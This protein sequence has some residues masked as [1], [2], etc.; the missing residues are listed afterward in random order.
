MKTSFSAIFSV[1]VVTTILAWS[2]D[3]SHLVGDR[4]QRVAEITRWVCI[5]ASYAMAII[6]LI[7]GRKVSRG[8]FFYT[9]VMVGVILPSVISSKDQVQ[10]LIAFTRLFSFA[11]VA[12]LVMGASADGRSRLF[13]VTFAALLFL[14]LGSLP[15]L[16]VG[17]AL[18]NL[19]TIAGDLDRTRF[20]GLTTHPNNLAFFATCVYAL[21]LGVASSQ[22]RSCVAGWKFWTAVT[23]GVLASIACFATGSRTGMACVITFPFVLAVL[24][25][26]LRDKGFASR[27]RRSAVVVV[28]AVLIFAPL[29]VTIAGLGD[30]S[31]RGRS[32]DMSNHSRFVAWRAS[33]DAF[34]DNPLTGVGVGAGV[35]LTGA[36]EERL[37]YSHNVLLTWLRNSGLFAG[38]LALTTILVLASKA[39][40]AIGSVAR[41]QPGYV[42]TISSAL[43]L[44]A[45]IG[46][47][48]VDGAL[49][50][51]YIFYFLPPLLY[52]FIASEPGKVGRAQRESHQ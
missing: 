23:V 32:Y 6:A 2:I 11:P 17:D 37:S 45:I 38:L 20:S 26:R 7:N 35:D 51:N 33:L 16:R 21:C 24:A 18:M 46:F 47:S 41:G 3:Y 29:Y 43:S 14:V 44:L 42:V 40:A 12:L 25:Y 31:G 13:I 19:R 27:L 30:D 52:A 15:L 10:S 36:F 8:L 48:A 49:Q 4:V 9:L 39:A 5:F 22:A 1:V 50:G 28:T 34:R